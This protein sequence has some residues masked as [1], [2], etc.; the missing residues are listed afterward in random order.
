MNA[1]S[2]LQQ[3]RNILYARECNCLEPPGLSFLF[4]LE[5]FKEIQL[6]KLNTVLQITLAHVNS[7]LRDSTGSFTLAY[8]SVLRKAEK[9]KHSKVS[10]SK[11][12][13]RKKAFCFAV[14]I[15]ITSSDNS[16]VP[17]VASSC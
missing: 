4:C 8:Q 9:C 16:F 11:K 5:Y 7:Q 1:F 12:P 10:L 14:V 13:G 6:E 15:N 2:K 3:I 17:K